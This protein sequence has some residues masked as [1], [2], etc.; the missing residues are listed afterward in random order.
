M[1]QVDPHEEDKKAPAAKPKGGNK[2]GSAK[3]KSEPKRGTKRKRTDS[4]EE[5]P[6]DSVDSNEEAASYGDDEDSEDDGDDYGSKKKGSSSSGGRS[7][8]VPS[9]FTPEDIEPKKS[10]RVSAKSKKPEDFAFPAVT[11]RQKKKIDYNMDSSSDSADYAESG[12]E[13]EE[14]EDKKSTTSSKKS[15]RKEGFTAPQDGDKHVE[16]ILAMRAKNV[17]AEKQPS[18]TT[19]SSQELPHLKPGNPEDP[20]SN[21]YLVKYK[22][23]AYIHCAWVSADFIEAQKMG[24]QK[25]QRFMNK[26]ANTV[27]PEDPFP[28]DWVVV[29]ISSTPSQ[30]IANLNNQ[31]RTC[32]R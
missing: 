15:S 20:Q 8:K 25:L 23:L 13:G 1:K 24:K 21:E 19:Q 26:V 27:D 32:C 3:A 5:E 12:D 28:S 18:V 17:E 11:L 9:R 10:T 30:F 14:E 16:K 31:G 2:R 29:S 7:R 22:D 6:E 4:D